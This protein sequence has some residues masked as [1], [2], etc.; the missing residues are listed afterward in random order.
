MVSFKGSESLSNIPANTRC[1]T[2]EFKKPQNDSMAEVE[3]DPWFSRHLEQSVQAHE[4][5]PQRLW[6]SVTLLCHLQST[7]VASQKLQLG[8]VSCHVFIATDKLCY[9]YQTTSQ[10]FLWYVCNH[11]SMKLTGEKKNHAFC[12]INAKCTKYKYSQHSP[13]ADS[14]CFPNGIYH[15]A[16]RSL[17]SS[18]H[19]VRYFL[20]G[21]QVFARLTLSPSIFPGIMLRKGFKAYVKKWCWEWC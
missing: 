18:F 8:R 16:W 7:E 19:R 21:Q 5:P 17:Y 4:D 13:L 12:Q 10:S 15:A 14:I 9:M 20:N 6:V 3:R 1:W 11:A 2:D